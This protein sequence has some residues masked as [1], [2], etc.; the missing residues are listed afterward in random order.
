MNGTGETHIA[1]EVPSHWQATLEQPGWPVTS[2]PAHADVV[3]V[4][5]GVLGAATAYWLARAGARPLLL[6]RGQPPAGASGRNAGFHGFG[7]AEMYHDAI[8]RLGHA[9]AREVAHLTLKSRE[10]LRQVLAEEAIACDYREPG[11][12]LLALN[13][14]Q[15]ASQAAMVARLQDDGFDAALIDR[16]QVQELIATPLGP[17]VAGGFFRPGN[18]L[19]HSA[20]LVHGL[21]RAAERHGAQVRPGCEV[22]AIKSRA[23]AV[24]I[25]TNRGQVQAG[26]AVV[27]VN[28]WTQRL[29][30]ALWGVVAPVR[31]Q[32]LAYAPTEPVFTCAMAADLTT[33]G[34]YWQQ[35]PDGAI[36]LGGCRTYGD[37]AEVGV[38]QAVP[39]EAVQ[40]AL[41][42]VFPRL[43]P[44]LAGLRVE[45]RWAGLM[46]FTADYLPVAD[47]AP[48]LSSVWVTGGFCGHGMPFA[49]RMGQLLAEAAVQGAA[50]AGLAPF[51]ID[52]ATL[53]RASPVEP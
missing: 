47:R 28:A 9:T 1:H 3:V 10:L 50:P 27:A 21:V 40:Q 43:F 13:D 26:A 42:S 38:E 36:V 49:M 8:A 45:R 19:L 52:R 15:L 30:P 20:R 5:A 6:D 35:T 12:L 41:E 22:R 16:Q 17:E 37:G 2:P 39:T 46:A 44:S 32:M 34:E 4:G 14:T 29:L 51:R 48:G 31:G 24:Q 53:R 11:Y 33:T 25:D 7:T 18:G 23:G